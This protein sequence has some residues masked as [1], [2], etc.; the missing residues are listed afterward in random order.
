MAPA[1]GVEREGGRFE[2]ASPHSE[3]RKA[4][5]S[6]DRRRRHGGLRCSARRRPK[7]SLPLGGQKLS[8]PGCAVSVQ[9]V[10]KHLEERYRREAEERYR[11][12][13]DVLAAMPEDPGTRAN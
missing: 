4:S 1:V 3:V 13:D 11:R 8:D 9:A 10:S 12:L 2:A 7:A 5:A 6:R